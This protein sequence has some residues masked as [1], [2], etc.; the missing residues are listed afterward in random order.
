MKRT[1]GG[2]R[3]TE[4]RSDGGRR[5]EDSAEDGGRRAEDGGDGVE[6]GNATDSSPELGVVGGESTLEN[7]NLTTEANGGETGAEADD[8]KEVEAL[9]NLLAEAASRAF[10]GE[11]IGD[12][13]DWGGVAGAG[14]GGPRSTRRFSRA[15]RCCRRFPE[16]FQ[17]DLVSERG[18]CGGPTLGVRLKVS[19]LRSY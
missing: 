14:T 5:A 18:P 10:S 8:L 4:E 3:R 15:S 2:G 11:N 12:R 13:A 16:R 17:G 9:R 1:E 19:R 6:A 7:K